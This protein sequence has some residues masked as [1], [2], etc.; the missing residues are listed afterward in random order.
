MV[1]LVV[2]LVFGGFDST[3]RHGG[4]YGE[5]IVAGSGGGDG[6][7]GGSVLMMVMGV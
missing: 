3:G 6:R 1:K 7:Y 4:G 5:S 2:V